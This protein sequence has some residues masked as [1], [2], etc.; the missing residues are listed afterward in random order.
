MLVLHEKYVIFRCH[1]CKPFSPFK[2]TKLFSASSKNCISG[3]CAGALNIHLADAQFLSI[4]SFLKIQKKLVWRAFAVFYCL[5][6]AEVMWHHDTHSKTL[7]HFCW[8]RYCKFIVIVPCKSSFFDKYASL[9]LKK[10]YYIKSL[11]S[12]CENRVEWLK[13]WRASEGTEYKIRAC[14]LGHT[15]VWR[16]VYWQRQQRPKRYVT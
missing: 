11:L 15:I 14:S 1:V 10:F 9:R 16:G 12:G 7:Q 6:L 2:F 13:I 4:L 5:N 3:M 8:H